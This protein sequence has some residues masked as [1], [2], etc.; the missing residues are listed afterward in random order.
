VEK[1]IPDLIARDRIPRVGITV[2]KATITLRIAAQCESDSEF[3]KAIEPTVREIRDALGVL[4]YGEGEVEL[5]EVV[6]QLLRDKRLRLGV[7]EVGAGCRICHML[8]KEQTNSPYALRIARW[9]VDTA[10]LRS[11]LRFDSSPESDAME[12][13]QLL[14]LAAESTCKEY[15]LDLCLAAGIYPMLEDVRSATLLP[16]SDFTLC[17]ARS[18]RSTKSTTVTLGGHPEVIYHRLAKTALN[19]LRI[20]LLR[21]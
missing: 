19:F 11:A 18:G 15:G 14:S 10:E 4:V 17:L 16:Y 5:H 8:A 13:T 20:D 6:S 1:A 7:I 2:S 12:L 21:A 3:S 9:L